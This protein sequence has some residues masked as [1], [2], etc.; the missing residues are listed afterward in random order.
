M[1]DFPNN[2]LSSQESSQEDSSNNIISENI[3]TDDCLTLIIEATNLEKAG[4]INKAISIYDQVIEVDKEGTYKAIAQKALAALETV[5]RENYHTENRDEIQS[6]IDDNNIQSVPLHKRLLKRFYD[7]PIQTKQ[8]A[9]LLTSEIGSIL[10]L[11][12][13][14]AILIVSNGRFQ[15]VNQAKSEL[16]VAEI[17]YNLKIEQMELTFDSQSNNLGI[18][19]AAEKQQANGQVLTTLA[20][21]LHK[22][23]IE[24]V[25]LVDKKRMIVATGKITVNKTAFDPYGLVTKALKTGEKNQFTE[26]IPYDELAQ[27]NSF[28]ARMLAH[29]IGIDPATK[30]DFLIRYTIT[31]IRNGKAEIV[32]ALISGDVVKEPIV[33]NTLTAFNNGYSAVYLYQ[34]SGEFS[35][36][37]A[38]LLNSQGIIIENPDLP[39]NKILEK[40]IDA[41]GEIVTQVIQ[42]NNKPHTVAAKALFNYENKPIG[43]LLRGTPHKAL[44][45][46]ILQSLGLQAMAALLAIVASVIL[47]KLLGQAIL[48]PLNQ[49]RK[50]T[51]EFSSG[52]RQVRAEKFANDEMGELATTFNVM[53][54][55]I[56]ASEAEL[57]YYAEQQEKEAENQRKARENLKQE[58]IKMLLDIEE[59]QQGNLTVEAEVTDGVVGSVA[60]AFNMTI[61]S[62]RDLVSKVQSVCYE[63]ND[64]VLEKEKEVTNLSQAAINQAQEMNQVFAG[65]ADINNSIQSV[66]SSTQEAANIA[67]LARQ[68]AQEGDIAM[69]Q[70]VNSIQK[71][72]GSVAG[73]AKKL[74]KLAESSQEISQIVTII[75]SI[76]EKTNVLAFNASIEASRAGEHGQGFKTVS[77]EVSRLAT[78]VTEA[79]QDIQYLVETIQEDTSLVLEDMEKSTTEVV[80][81]TQLIRQTQEILQ[82]LAMT[83]ENID[84]YL[85]QITQ[86][87]GEQTHASQQINQK[88]HQIAGISQQTSSQTENVVK[89]LHVL[90]E[91][92]KVLQI[93]VEK[94]RLQS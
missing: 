24:L 2:S 73:T 20:N 45:T 67:K 63:V 62:L 19:E 40:A 49:L 14:G 66:A 33:N 28:S 56:V 46:L 68:Q 23:Q 41:Q 30:P 92:M 85:Q 21:E 79:T 54:D 64:L 9:V 11:V 81:G 94:F 5:T 3:N 70:T 80:T 57:S 61:R 26:I 82:S 27:E 8:L 50:I 37:T 10:T 32:G 51:T 15:L 29:D 31:P 4:D 1:L 72:R 90:V 60:D 13:V 75:S 77:E 55:S 7:L 53:A 6:N 38:Q 17:N 44:N 34:N 59:A 52:N 83:S 76:S 18:I 89:S 69:N 48:K 88:I 86:N 12:G 42:I 35:L 39:N 78:R 71:I 91:E 43:V 74:K 84:D 36:A 25:T 47:A 16:K 65:V 87:T 58:V 22:Q 93:S